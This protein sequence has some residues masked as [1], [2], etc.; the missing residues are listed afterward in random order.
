[1]AKSFE[2]D[3]IDTTLVPVGD[4]FVLEF[5]ADIM[6]LFLAFGVGLDPRQGATF[7]PALGP[8]LVG[9]ALGGIR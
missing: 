9:A 2:D 8:I 7:G 1:M 3:E 5:M 6:L 4:I